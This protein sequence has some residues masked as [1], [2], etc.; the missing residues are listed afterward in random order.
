MQYNY[1]KARER[2]DIVKISTKGRYA[3]RMMTDLAERGENEL[4]PLK[5]IAHRQQIS[6]KYLEQIASILTRAGYVKSV[7]GT[8]GGYKLARRPEDYTVGMILRL[9][10]GNLAPVSC[11]EFENNTCPRAGECPTLCVWK[12][13]Y[14]AIND[15]VDQVT[16]AELS[17][18]RVSTEGEQLPADDTVKKAGEP[19]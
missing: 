6:M 15:V 1:D 3:L 17:G 5:E 18:Q 4:V 14:S 10:E 2:A 13:L 16:L 9:T 8:G 7:R 11:L 12:K 19:F